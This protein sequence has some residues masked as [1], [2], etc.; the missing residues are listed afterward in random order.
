M[1]REVV[2]NPHAADFAPYLHAARDSL[3]GLQ[4]VDRVLNGN[5]GMTRRRDGSKRV[6]HVMSPDQR[7]LYGA[8]WLARLEHFESR[9]VGDATH[10]FRGPQRV[11][12]TVA[13]ESLQRRPT[14]HLQGLA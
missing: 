10:R 5:P 4:G 1:V 14:A 11:L 6:L 7:P 13:R 3:E 9:V 2:I 12:A 8:A